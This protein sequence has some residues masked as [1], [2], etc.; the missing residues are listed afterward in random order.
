M[1]FKEFAIN[2]LNPFYLAMRFALCC[3]AAACFVPTISPVTENKLL[4]PPVVLAGCAAVLCFFYRS[5]FKAR[6]VLA[7]IVLPPIV[8]VLSVFMISGET[9]KNI[10]TT[11]GVLGLWSVGLLMLWNAFRTW[12]TN[13]MSANDVNNAVKNYSRKL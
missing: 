3:Y 11:V 5:I 4:V 9:S 13:Y 12:G 7:N 10:V 6:P 1:S 2:Y 8:F